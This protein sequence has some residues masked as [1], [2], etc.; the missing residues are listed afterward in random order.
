MDAVIDR[1]FATFGPELRYLSFG[2]EVDRYLASVSS[3]ERSA[4]TD[5][6]DGALAYAKNH[7]QRQSGTQFGV[8]FSLAGLATNRSPQTTTL[9]AA[10]DLPIITDLPLDSTFH[11]LAP[12]AAVAAL[13][14]LPN[15]LAATGKG[16][17]QIVVQSVGYPSST[18]VGSS[19]SAQ[20]QFYQA[21]SRLL[22]AERE[23]FPF[24][25]IDVASDAEVPVCAEAAQ[26]YGAAT[27]PFLEAALCSLGLTDST[28][29]EKPAWAEVLAALSLFG[30][31]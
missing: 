17:A 1:A 21:L 25:V 30:K 10:S 8:A 19:P 2:R 11:A 18:V 23:R 29:S 15:A 26:S 5:F 6:F 14:A 24:V 12:Q 31:P 4:A 27:D 3:D 28:G 13:A 7:S 16:N 9:L 22:D 20:Q